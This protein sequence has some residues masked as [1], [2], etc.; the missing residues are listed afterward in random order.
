[1]TEPMSPLRRRWS[2]KQE[3][4]GLLL[5]QLMQGPQ[6]FTDFRTA[7]PALSDRLLSQRLKDLEAE[8]IINRVVID[9]M[10]VQIRYELT[11]KGVPWH[12]WWRRFRAGPKNGA[13]GRV[14]GLGR[15]IELREACVVAPSVQAEAAKAHSLPSGEQDGFGEQPVPARSE[16]QGTTACPPRAL[17]GH[18]SRT[19]Q[20]S[21]V[22]TFR[23]Q[24][25]GGSPAA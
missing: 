11:D 3:W 7:I 6:R 16:K 25:T 22:P 14:T 1:M 9:S 10:P 17:S 24:P 5:R 23:D 13:D 18:P 19:F 20:P 8:G 4:T 2:L 12:R 15:R 21:I